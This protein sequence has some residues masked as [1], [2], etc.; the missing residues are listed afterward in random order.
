MSII[1]SRHMQ[2]SA[3]RREF[4]AA[5]PFPHLVLDDFLDSV[6]FANLK[7]A[8]SDVTN[9]AAGKTFASAVEE[10]KWISLNST[11]PDAIRQVV[12]ALNDE[13]WIENIGE[14]TGL[15]A[16]LSTSN[17]N[18]RLANYHVMEPGAVLGPHV[19][20][21]SEPTLGVPHVFNV[22]VYLT[23][24]WRESSG[25]ATFFYDETGS[26]VVTKV[27]YQANRAVLFLHTPYSFHGVERVSLDASLKRRTIYVDYYSRSES[28]YVNMDLSFDHRWFKHGTTFKLNSVL[29]YLRPANSSYTKALL[30]YHLNKLLAKLA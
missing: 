4:L 13:S 17:D 9:A 2:L 15:P 6:F 11:L 8:F 26:S 5:A 28:P 18:T 10:K 14:L 29:D 21:A 7:E 1:D 23:E 24:S 16:L 25:G 22:I 20:H 19:D 30:Q 12:E 27:P 3:R